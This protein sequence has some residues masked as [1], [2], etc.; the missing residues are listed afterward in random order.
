MAEISTGLLAEITPFLMFEG[1]AEEAMTFYLSLFD[2]SEVVSITRY[3]AEGPG[4]EGT[5]E[6]AVFSLNGQTFMCIDSNV[7]HGFS[8]TPAISFFVTCQ[9]A[10]EV[11]DLYAKL[12]NGGFVA[13][14]LGEYPFSPKFGWVTDRFGVSWQISMPPLN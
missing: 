12:S 5:I 4:T 14:P 2:Q 7:A 6:R 8:F 3:G 11:D 1:K 9:T 13:M 10:E